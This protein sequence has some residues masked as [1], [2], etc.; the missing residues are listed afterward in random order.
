MIAKAKMT[1]SNKTITVMLMAIIVLSACSPAVSKT[2]SPTPVRE[3]TL[4]GDLSLRQIGDGAYVITHN[5]PWPANSLL[6][7]MKDGT[8][9]MAGTPYTPEA[10][11]AVLDWAKS[12]FG[13]RKIVAI[14]T[15]YHPDNLGGNQALI[16]AGIPVYGSDLTVQLLQ[17]RGEKTRQLMLSMIG[18]P[19]SSY[20]AVYQKM[21]Y[22]PPDHVFPIKNGLALNFGG[23]KLQVIYPGPS[24]APDKV[25]VYFPDRKLLFGSCMIFGTDKIGNTAD[26]DMKNW[27]EAVKSLQKY[28][29]DVVVPGHGDR[30][31]PGLI[32]HTLDLLAAVP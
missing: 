31:D 10:T 19:N 22:V 24:Q 5:Y 4:A 8:L 7:E 20:Y 27:P 3:I 11:R 15:G 29:V 13:Q 6:V 14:D 28:P 9:V 2:V 18:D 26:A 23:E 25:V 12:Q 30:L 16:D 17:E 21:V 32:Q 1:R